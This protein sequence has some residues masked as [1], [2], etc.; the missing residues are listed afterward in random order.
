MDT[1]IFLAF[2]GLL[3][4]FLVFIGLQRLLKRWFPKTVTRNV[5]ATVGTLVTAPILYTVMITLWFVWASY[6]PKRDFDRERWRS[7]I[8]TRY[9]MSD[10]I[11]ESKML[12]G[13]SKAEV[14]Q[15]LEVKPEKREWPDFNADTSDYWRYYLGF[16]PSVLGPM[17]PDALDIYFEDGRVVRVGQ[18]RT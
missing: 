12:I 4:L 11:I 18:H 14:R 6:Y 9:E 5:V 7:S 3:I 8:E 15:L 2:V 1:L 16:K 13:K 17:D 10:D